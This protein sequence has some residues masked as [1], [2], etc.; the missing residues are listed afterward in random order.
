MKFKIKEYDNY[1][2]RDILPL[3][4]NA[5]WTNYTMQ[6]KMIEK[7]YNNSLC[8]LVAI[9]DERV[10]GVVRAVGDGASVLFVQDIIVH[11]DFQ[12]KGIGR[13]LL[14][15]L[16]AKYE[17][18]YQIELATDNTTKLIAFYKSFGFMAG[19]E[20]GCELM[21]RQNLRSKA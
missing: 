11:S 19:S 7:A 4:Q 21:M 18:V 6:P 10:I 16:L 15:A 14:E 12:R 9:V 2:E 3:Y 13:A 20:I 5:G 1:C 8:T 17:N